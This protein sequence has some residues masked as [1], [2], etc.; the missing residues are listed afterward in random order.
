LKEKLE[1]KK[2][3]G[4]EPPAKMNKMDFVLFV[5]NLNKKNRNLSLGRY[6]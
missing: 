3:I 2:L 4:F 6:F 5:H 1:S